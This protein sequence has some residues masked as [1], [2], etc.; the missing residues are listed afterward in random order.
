LLRGEAGQDGL[1]IP[2]TWESVRVSVHVLAATVWIG[3]QIVL[4]ALVP[5][6]RAFGRDVVRAAARR[7]N[8]VAWPAY[9][10]LV[11]TGVGNVIATG[12][13]AGAYRTTLVV[14]IILVA[15]SGLAAFLHQRAR[16]PTAL[17]GF[18]ALSL[19]AAIG[20]AVLGV[21]LG[22]GG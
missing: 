18:G 11:A 14:K 3:G 1:V 6:L 22:S 8:L 7:F 21:L 13:G 15:V 17:A 10:V 16:T 2:V 9:G 5:A 4:A 12:L 19:L 20:A